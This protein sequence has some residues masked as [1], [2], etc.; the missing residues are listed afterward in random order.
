[1]S[2]AEFPL[3][4]NRIGGI[5]RILGCRF[6]YH[7]GPEAQIRSLAWEVHMLWGGQKKKEKETENKRV[8]TEGERLGGGDKLGV[9]D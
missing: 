4:C 6:N 7:P 1:M 2:Y 3:W 9:R 8:V 5:L